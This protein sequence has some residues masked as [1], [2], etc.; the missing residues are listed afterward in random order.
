MKVGGHCD[1]T[2][3]SYLCH[4][5]LGVMT[6]RTISWFKNVLLFQNLLFTI[7]ELFLFCFFNNKIH[8]L[9]YLYNIVLYKMPNRY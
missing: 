2:D 8:V 1:V 4:S 9:G 7:F 6:V 3:N 5:S